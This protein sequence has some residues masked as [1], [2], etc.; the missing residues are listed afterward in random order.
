MDYAAEQAERA[1]DIA[2]R[3]VE[4]ATDSA[5]E[6]GLL[7]QGGGETVAQKVEK[8]AKSA[9]DAAKNETKSS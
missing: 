1:Q 5:K 7:P 6:E 2:Q 3:T 9:K 8:V 4:A